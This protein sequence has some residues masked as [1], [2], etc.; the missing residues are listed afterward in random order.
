MEWRLDYFN[1]ISIIQKEF[2]YKVVE[3]LQFLN[4]SITIVMHKGFP[5]FYY[6][7]TFAYIKLNSNSGLSTLTF[8]RGFL[9]DENRLKFNLGDI[10]TK[11]RNITI[12][13][14]NTVNWLEIQEYLVQAI[15]WQEQLSK[16]CN[17]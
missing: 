8:T 7:G 13:T 10:E 11:E 15:Y 5:G 3:I 14:S 16:Q 4:P 12:E 6:R 17:C 1:N 2:Y 9:F